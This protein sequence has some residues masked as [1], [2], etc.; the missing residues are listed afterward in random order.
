[1][2]RTLLTILFGGHKSDRRADEK[3]RIL[4]RTD[5]VELIGQTIDLTKMGSGKYR[6]YCPFH[7]EPAGSTHSFLV[8][9][10][11]QFFFC[12]RCK[13]GGDAFSFVK[14]RDRV[15][16]PVAFETLARSVANSVP[17]ALAE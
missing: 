3:T 9:P 2:Q 12:H 5:I 1:M 10:R 4:A 7:K 6:G 15:E 17:R 8:D 13:V 14:M 16:Y 11:K